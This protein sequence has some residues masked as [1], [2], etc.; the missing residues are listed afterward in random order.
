VGVG[1][2]FSDVFYL[3]IKPH[4]I[5]ATTIERARMLASTLGSEHHSNQLGL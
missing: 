5:S 2:P 3:P 1:I 4:E